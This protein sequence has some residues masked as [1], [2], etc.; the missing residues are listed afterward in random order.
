MLT[1]R[2][3]SRDRDIETY[4]TTKIEH[5]QEND[6][7]NNLIKLWNYKCPN[8]LIL[9]TLQVT[10]LLLKYKREALEEGL[11]LIRPLW[12]VSGSDTAP[13]PVQDEFAI[14]GEIVVAPILERGQT[15]RD[16][17][18]YILKLNEEG[19]NLSLC[20]IHRHL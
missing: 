15:T 9:F 3:K 12:L 19:H 17:K 2:Y 1:K 5:G 20:I 11:P 16:G 8:F 6:D 13:M 4:Y 14:G 7:Y 18:Y 10:P